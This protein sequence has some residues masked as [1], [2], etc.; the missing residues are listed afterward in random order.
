[1]LEDRIAVAEGALVGAQ[2]P[3]ASVK[4]AL[5]KAMSAPD[6]FVLKPGTIVKVD[7]SGVDAAG[8]DFVEKALI[9]RLKEAGFDA[10]PSGSIDLIAQTEVGQQRQI[11]YRT[12]GRL[13]TETYN[14]RD[15][16]SRVKF[17][18]QG[19]DVDQQVHLGFDL[20][21]T[22]MIGVTAAQDGRVVHA[23]DLGIFGNCV[24]IDHG[25]GVQSLYGH[26]SSITVKVGDT[27]TKEQELG[28]S[29]MTGLAGG[30]HL[31]FTMLVNGQMVNPIEWW[32]AHW[33][34][35]RILRKLK[36]AGF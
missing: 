2:L 6:F 15:Y 5:A 27:V 24:I 8:K 25:L 30:D 35:D 20:A 3:A 19:K 28:K 9:A 11:S 12:F 29:G 36:D 1:M 23:G 14:V 16:Y 21:V 17:V 22:A 33:I 13:G 34:Q 7:V 18:Y 32:D 10:G 4:D 31:H 26:L